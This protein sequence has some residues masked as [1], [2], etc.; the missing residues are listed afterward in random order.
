VDLEDADLYVRPAYNAD[1]PVIVDA[2]IA[3]WFGSA[4]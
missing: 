4:S 3:E 1:D 2:V